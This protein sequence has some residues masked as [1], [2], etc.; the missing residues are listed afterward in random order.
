MRRETDLLRAAA[1]RAGEGDFELMLAAAASA[2]PPDQAAIE[3]L[4]F[5]FDAGRLTLSAPGWNAQQ[6]DAFRT[7]LAPAGWA[8]DARDGRITISRAT[9]GAQS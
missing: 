2:W 1:G 7:R 3:A 5:E 8:V 4:K 9:I 6:I